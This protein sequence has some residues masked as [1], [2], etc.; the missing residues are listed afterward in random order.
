LKALGGS[1]APIIG[2][3]IMELFGMA[4]CETGIAMDRFV[5][6]TLLHSALSFNA[7]QIRCFHLN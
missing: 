1:C 3:V 5:L 7:G 2:R 4:I 6:A